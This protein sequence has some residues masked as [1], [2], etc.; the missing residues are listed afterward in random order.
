MCFVG[1]TV[2]VQK[3]GT[4]GP[5]MVKRT[6]SGVAEPRLPLKRG[7]VWIFIRNTATTISKTM[8]HSELGQDG[9]LVSCSYGKR[10]CQHLLE[11]PGARST[12]HA[13]PCIIR[14][15][16]YFIWKLDNEALKRGNVRLTNVSFKKNKRRTPG[17]K[18]TP[19]LSSCCC[20]AAGEGNHEQSSLDVEQLFV[21]SSGQWT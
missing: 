18:S 5:S 12:L 17:A 7:P 16:I 10:V 14:N 20:N 6:S 8:C 11:K 15:E 3:Y 9:A 13:K 4:D 21:Q 19:G 1:L 2:S